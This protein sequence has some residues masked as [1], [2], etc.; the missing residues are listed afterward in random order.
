MSAGPARLARLDHKGSIAAGKDADLI[1]WDPDATVTIAPG[2][3]EHRHK[4]TPYSGE[5]LRGAVR[6]TLL[7]GDTIYDNGTFGPQSRWG[8]PPNPRPA[9]RLLGARA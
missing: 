1:V 7:R 6:A 9:G 8:V 3:I 4:I 5:A 2:M